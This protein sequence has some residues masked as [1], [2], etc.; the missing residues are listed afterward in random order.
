[1]LT[2]R[3]AESRLHDRLGLTRRRA[4]RV[5]ACGLAGDPERTPASLLYDEGRLDALLVRPPVSI[6]VLRAHADRGLFIARRD[7]DVRLPPADQLSGLEG[8]WRLSLPTLLW[9]RARIARDGS[10]PLVATVG[11]FVAAGADIT[12]AIGDRATTALP[13]QP[14]VGRPLPRTRLELRSAGA[15]FADF[16]GRRLL[17]APGQPALV[18]GAPSAGGDDLAKYLRS[19]R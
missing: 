6:A 11:G 15:W 14:V 5:L 10:V 9:I 3:Q 16:A 8:G 12:G 18:V 2:S 13:A 7:V 1:M 19:L 4:R 17:T